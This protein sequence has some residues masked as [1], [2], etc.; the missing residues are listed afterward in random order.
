MTSLALVL[1]ASRPVSPFFVPSAQHGC[2]GGGGAG[3]QFKFP[4]HAKDAVTQTGEAITASLDDGLHRIRLQL[5]LGEFQLG[6]AR[7]R[8]MSDTLVP[9]L[10][11]SIAALLC[12]R[13]LRVNLFFNS[14]SD[15]SEARAVLREDLKERVAINVLGLGEFSS[16]HDVAVLFC[17]SNQ[18]NGNLQRIEEVERIIYA[19]PPRSMASRLE[20]KKF[21]IRPILLFN[22]VLEAVH[23]ASND[24]RKVPPMF[25]SDFTTA[26]F[27]QPHIL[28]SRTAEMALLRSHPSNW[29]LW[30][31]RN[32]PS[33][34][35]GRL[36]SEFQ[37]EA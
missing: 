36:S 15:A 14:L 29:Q 24:I 18:G 13:G 28:T 26:Y 23:A 4:E 17:P 5:N 34:S 35:R 1:L 20:R 10:M 30:M 32:G 21:L 8:K 7:E 22:P 16:D 19:G 37:G 6:G 33:A 9:V 31:R 3:R 25:L 27:L 11:N 12:A 2:A